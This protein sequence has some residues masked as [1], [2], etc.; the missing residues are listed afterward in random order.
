MK[1]AQYRIVD[2]PAFDT[3]VLVILDCGPWTEFPTITNDAE[4]VVED[5]VKAGRLK[6]GMRLMYYDS[7]GALDELRI[8]NGRFAGFAPG[9]Q[10]QP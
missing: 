8:Y 3:N 5:L 10:V 2:E 6:P 9:P 1:R 7:E 4:R